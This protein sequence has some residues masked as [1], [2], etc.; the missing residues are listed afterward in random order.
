MDFLGALNLVLLF[1]L[2]TGLGCAIDYSA[3]RTVL[4][5]PRGVAVGLLSQFVVL[6]ALAAGVATV[7]GLADVFAVG[8][9]VMCCCPGGAISN[10]LCLL[11]QA[12]I[13]LSVACTAA[14]SSLAVVALPLNLLLYLK[15]TGLARGIAID[16]VGV[17]LSALAV[18]LG[19]GVGVGV[20]HLAGTAARP[21]ASPSATSDAGKR[22]PP[23]RFERRR[24]A[25]AAGVLGVVGSIAGLGLV[26]VGFVLNARS[27]TPL[28]RAPPKVYLC[29]GLTMIAGC[30][31][32]RGPR[33]ARRHRF[34]R[35]VRVSLS[36]SRF[37]RLSTARAASRA[38]S[39]ARGSRAS[40]R[41]RASRSRSRRA[42]RTS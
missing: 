28:W 12:D 39:A 10:V 33:S 6:P 32:A 7:A 25:R 13:A 14:S 16:Y 24:F 21:L 18:V 17:A 36:Q 23:K 11:F 9:V 26:V 2:M 30:A 34:S 22:A 19:T 37:S 4:R 35:S 1:M 31:R 5:K 38:A 41:P 8:L 40:A 3:L 20:A 29:T 15:L 42:S 27:Q